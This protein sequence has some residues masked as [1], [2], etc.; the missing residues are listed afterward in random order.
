MLCTMHLVS[1]T[2][3]WQA[4]RAE[5]IDKNIAGIIAMKTITIISIIRMVQITQR[6]Y[7]IELM[8][9]IIRIAICITIITLTIVIIATI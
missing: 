3:Q 2:G 9:M 5:Q 6:F 4:R 7:R 8:I 1:V